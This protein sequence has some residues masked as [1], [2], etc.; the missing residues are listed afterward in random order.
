MSFYIREPFSDATKN[1]NENPISQSIEK[2]ETIDIIASDITRDI[3]ENLIPKKKFGFKKKL[4]I[5]ISTLL[6]VCLVSLASIGGYV[7]A[8]GGLTNN[9]VL[10]DN[11]NS[12]TATTL[13][14]NNTQTYQKM[15]ASSSSLTIPEIAAKAAPSVVTVICQ[16]YYG[17]STGSGII[18]SDDGYILTNDHVVNGA[19][20]VKVVLYQQTEDEA[21]D[22]EIIGTDSQTDLAVIKIDASGQ[23]LTAAEF[24]DSDNLKVGETAVAIGNPLG[25]EFAG[26]VTK[27]VISALGR[28][29]EIDG[30]EMTMIQTDA[31]INPGNSGGPLVND[32]GQVIGINSVK[33]SSAYAEGLG[34]AIPINSAL[35]I[36]NELIENG[37]I[38]GRPSIGISG[39]DIDSTVSKY[40]HIPQGVAV[41]LVDPDSGAASAGIKAGD[42]ITGINGED[43]TSIDELNV[44]KN[45]FKAGDTVTLTIYRDEQTIKVDVVLHDAAETN[46]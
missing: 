22:A 5:G 12:I 25:L 23:D 43:I 40:Y 3:E 13:N 32:Q 26:S 15:S 45:K 14:D 6:V 35:P 7:V 20:S 11:N 39:D 38:S 21:I 4:M 10:N 2:T 1:E 36:A 42:I 31:S 9:A 18:M 29:I 30:R 19:T 33:I 24:G 27:G 8:T 28:E 16:T 37:Y 44:I 17:E 41:A 34:F 46:N